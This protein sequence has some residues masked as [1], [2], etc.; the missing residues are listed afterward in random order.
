MSMPKYILR[1]CTAWIGK[2]S[3]LGQ[4]S[5][6]MIPVPKVKVEELRNAGMVMPIE[7]NLGYEKPDNLE[8]KFTGLDPDIIKL[9]G[10]AVG[11]LTDFTITGALADEDGTIHGAS[12]DLLGFFVETKIDT[13]QAGDKKPE[14]EY[15][16]SVR[17]LDLQIDGLPVLSFDPFDV[18]VGGIST[19]NTI[20]RAM[21]VS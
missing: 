1:N 6:V 18:R 21:R 14:N 9:H 7:V 13:W 8:F 12:V 15:K 19:Y 11:V 2:V 5:E 10:L 4:M 20:R 16:I 3:Q 17:E